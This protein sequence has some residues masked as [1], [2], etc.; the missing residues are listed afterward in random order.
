MDLV[1]AVN[2]N[3]LLFWSALPRNIKLKNNSLY[4][5]HILIG[6]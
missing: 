1:F 6:G 5:I 2:L 3:Y 4:V